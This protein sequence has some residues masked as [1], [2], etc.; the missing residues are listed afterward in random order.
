[1]TRAGVLLVTALVLVGGSAALL[2]RRAEHEVRPAEA[3]PSAPSACEARS[4]EGAAFTVCR[5]DARRDVLALFQADEAGRPYRTFAAVEQAL[6]AS[7]A[8][9]RFAMNAGMFDEQGKPIGLYVEDGVEQRALNRREGPG[10]FHLL[11]N[12]VFAQ[13]SKG[14]VSVSTA[15]R[16]GSE[17]PDPRWA[18]QSG[19]MLV[20]DGE[21]HPRIQPDGPSRLIRNGVGVSDP[22]TA[23]F[24]LS[25]TG[26]SFGLFARFFRD[27]LGCADALFLD[28]SV[29]SLWDSAAGRRDS[30]ADLGPMV[31]VSRR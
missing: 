23:W 17:V 25:E 30:H 28:G 5:F 4:F 3:P 22:H 11:P 13:D 10:N 12:G 21:L 20:I 15:E 19:P 14:R 31:V 9:V 1:M 27:E 6:G 26:V 24:V 16:F 2:G 8:K 7:A 29:S 18:T